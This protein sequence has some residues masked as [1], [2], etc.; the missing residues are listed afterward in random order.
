MNGHIY[1]FLLKKR[2]LTLNNELIIYRKVKELKYINIINRNLKYLY[3]R[4]LK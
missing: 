2:N 3:I 1:L 4:K